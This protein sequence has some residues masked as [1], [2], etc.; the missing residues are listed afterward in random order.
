[1]ISI[2]KASLLLLL[3]GGAVSV[4]IPGV[5][6]HLPGASTSSTSGAEPV[7]LI[8]A[9]GVQSAVAVLP[10]GHNSMPPQQQVQGATSG[11][12][13]VNASAPSG[14]ADEVKLP[15]SIRNFDTGTRASLL[16]K[17]ESKATEQPTLQSHISRIHLWVMKNPL[18]GI[19][20][21]PGGDRA[22]FGAKIYGEGQQVISGW[23]LSAIHSESVTFVHDELSWTT[24]LPRI[25]KGLPIK[26]TRNE[27]A[28]RAADT[29]T[30]GTPSG[31]NPPGG[32]Q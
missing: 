31:A 28:D 24:H 1:M 30:Q 32:N 12:S 8:V 5:R 22:F 4:W 2:K 11:S 14:S 13:T 20:Q 29:T 21:S 3:V 25:G 10:P 15:G 18:S 23:S 9:D 17:A 7:N 16:G 26:S 6:A 19:M 27:A